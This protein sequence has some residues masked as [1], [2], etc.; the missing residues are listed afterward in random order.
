M[1]KN[2][3]SSRHWWIVGLSVTAVL[4]ACALAGLLVFFRT[5]ALPGATV[6]E[7][8][9]AGQTPQ[10]V[11]ATLRESVAEQT[12]TLTGLDKDEVSIPLVET[13]VSVDVEETVTE[14]FAPNRSLTGIAQNLFSSHRVV[15]AVSV[16]PSRVENLAASLVEVETARPVDGAARFDPDSGTFY[17]QQ[18]AAGTAV[19]ET[20]LQRELEL[21][22]ESMRSGEVTVPTE[23]SQPQVTTEQALRAVQKANAFLD[24]ELWAV[25]S[26]GDSRSPDRQTRVNWISF[27]GVGDSYQ[28]EL[29]DTAVTQWADEF[30]DETTTSPV[31]GLR[32]V[33]ESGTELAVSLPA[34]DGYGVTNVDQV[35]K[36]FTDALLL[37]TDATVI[38]TYGDLP[39]TWQD[40]PAL[41]G[42]EN[43]P[44]RPAAGEKWLDLNLSTNSVTAYEGSTVVGG[45]WLMVPGEP[46]TPTVTGE[47]NV[48]LKY[49][50]QDMR[51]E[52]VDGS[53]YLTKDV[54]WVT[55][56]Y[57]GY[58]FH[59]APWRSSFGW[60]GPGGS[61]GCVNMEPVDAKFIYDW[62]DM[63]TK[64]ISRY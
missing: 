31:V 14:L 32:N 64:V 59:G 58:A 55:Y 12:V 20:K 1:G 5:H 51:G 19:D 22:A 33:D 41:E 9:V 11:T 27:T 57:G 47:Y 7:V 36:A 39:A 29:A 4:A 30:A 40:R 2:G 61:H 42:T 37:E 24:A 45:P 21:V 35:V 23:T 17:T 28:P 8:S 52:N 10:Q 15:P 38:F 63:G 60:S 46:R 34:Q 48:Y 18:A 43:L 54:P 49:E 26:Y 56:F 53:K 16:D 13:G 25:D 6:G 3:F 44:Y 50:I 62:A